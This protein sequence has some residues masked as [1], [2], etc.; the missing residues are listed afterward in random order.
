M[1]L[2]NDTETGSV[3]WIWLPG[4]STQILLLFIPQTG[5]RMQDDARLHD[6]GLLLAA[7]CKA[8]H[9]ASPS[10][11]SKQGGATVSAAAGLRKCRRACVSAGSTAATGGNIS[12]TSALTATSVDQLDVVTADDALRSSPANALGLGQLWALGTRD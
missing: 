4:G 9:A 2:S 3:L 12:C 11:H 10:P 5:P 8:A 6:G 1:V 7:P